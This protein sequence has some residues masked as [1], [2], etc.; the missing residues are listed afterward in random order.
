MY[1]SPTCLLLPYNIHVF[2]MGR[3]REYQQS[4]STKRA[5]ADRTSAPPTYFARSGAR[6]N[7]SLAA[8]RA[9]FPH[10]AREKSWR[11]F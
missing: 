7:R 6:T 8:P 2:V 4:R 3:V 1:E 11:P 9:H 5:P 10:I